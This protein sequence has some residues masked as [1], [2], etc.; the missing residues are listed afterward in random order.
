M[1]SRDESLVTQAFLVTHIYIYIYQL[2]IVEYV[3]SDYFFRQ[4]DY[5]T[6]VSDF[7][8]TFHYVF[9]WEFYN[10]SYLQNK[11]LGNQSSTCSSLRD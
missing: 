11:A 4:K 7:F 9:I 5:E 2:V 3:E 1:W 6:Y 10:L 8:R